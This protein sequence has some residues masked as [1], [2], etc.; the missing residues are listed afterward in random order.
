MALVHR[1][2]G[3][4]GCAGRLPSLL[5]PCRE[6]RWMGIEIRTPTDEDWPAI[7]RAD[8]RISGSWESP[9]RIEERRAIH[10]LS[11]FRIAVDDG[12]IVAVASSYGMEVTL[13]GGTTVP[14]GGVSWVSTSAT[15]RRQG[16]MRRV[17]GAV[18]D[19]IDA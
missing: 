4:G 10:D 5:A 6:T 2:H 9:E 19:D 14:M 8:D 18:H 13:P 3:R 17:V 16:F 12:E 1:A 15:H 7:C 11:R